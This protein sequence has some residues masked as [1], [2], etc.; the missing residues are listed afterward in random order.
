MRE[1]SRFAF[2]GVLYKVFMQLIPKLGFGTQRSVPFKS[3]APPGADMPRLRYRHEIHA[4]F[5]ALACVQQIHIAQISSPTTTR[6]RSGNLG[7]VPMK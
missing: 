3:T 6:Y 2:L 4:K 7:G 1:D 5:V